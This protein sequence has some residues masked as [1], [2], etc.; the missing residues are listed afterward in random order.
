MKPAKFTIAKEIDSNKAMHVDDV[1]NGKECNCICFECSEPL[2]A[3]NNGQIQQHHFRHI[4]DTNCSGGPETGLHKLAKQIVA[5]NS[6][7]LIQS[8]ATFQYNEAEVEY[9]GFKTIKPDV[10]ISNENEQWCIEP[11]VK[12]PLSEENKLTYKRLNLNCLQ[13]NLKAVDRSSSKAE[14][15]FEVLHN[16]N[17]RQ[18]INRTKN[19]EIKENDDSSNF[20]L[21]LFLGIVTLS[22]F[23][24][25][26]K[27]KRRY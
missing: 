27:R 10:F 7:I 13:I 8:N 24:R 20:L 14:L 18:I 5:E 3:A 12:N 25:K 9:Q 6:E 21:W 22:F 11:F 16:P 1:A 15:K 2:I 19:E 23:K 4:N 17:N 26:S